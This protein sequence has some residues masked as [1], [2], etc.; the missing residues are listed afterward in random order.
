MPS[1]FHERFLSLLSANYPEL[2]PIVK[3]KHD[4]YV[5]DFEG[6]ESDSWAFVPEKGKT[7]RVHI[8]Y[9]ITMGWA[10]LYSDDSIIAPSDLVGFTHKQEPCMLEHTNYMVHSIVDFPEDCYI[11]V[12]EG[13]PLNFAFFNTSGLLLYFDTTVW[14]LVVDQKHLPIVRKYIRNPLV[15]VIEK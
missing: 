11:E 7:G 15:C 8:V 13:N 3:Q 1:G 12:E 2:W 6:S 9:S 5:T 14:Y 10:R 4:T